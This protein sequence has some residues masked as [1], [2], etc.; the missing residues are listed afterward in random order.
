[1]FLGVD[2]QIACAEAHYRQLLEEA[3]IERMLRYRGYRPVPPQSR[4][5]G[6]LIAFSD[7]L[8]KAGQRIRA[9][10]GVS[11]MP[12]TADEVPRL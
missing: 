5:R 6:L 12:V 11:P 4:T 8:I 3:R 7:F 9:A 1:M 2:N 10:C